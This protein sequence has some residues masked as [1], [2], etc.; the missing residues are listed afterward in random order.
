MTDALPGDDA[1]EPDYI[2][3]SLDRAAWDARA[4]AD[5]LLPDL[6]RP[7]RL[8]VRATDALDRVRQLVFRC[9]RAECFVISARMR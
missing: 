9:E 3:R 5:E 6:L 8:V 2:H 1:P 7:V 4:V